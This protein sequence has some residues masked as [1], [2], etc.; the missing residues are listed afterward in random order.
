[1]TDA[2]RMEFDRAVEAE[3][4]RRAA[5]APAKVVA[6]KTT[7]VT[8]Y[9]IGK[10]QA[11]SQGEVAG[12]YVAEKAGQAVEAAKLGTGKAVGWLSGFVG[13]LRK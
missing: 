12:R 9:D 3:I 8:E 6:A 10:Y 13:G 11:R 1:M 5:L 7:V 4:A 2:E